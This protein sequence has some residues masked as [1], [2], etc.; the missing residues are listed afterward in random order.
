MATSGSIR[1]LTIEGI[2][3]DVM[4]DANFSEVF[5]QY[6]VEVIATSGKGMKKFTKRV[7]TVEG[8]V[9]GTSGADRERLK[10]W[11]EGLAD[12]KF[13]YTNAAGDTAKA[14]GHFNIESNESEE[15]RT[16]ITLMPT[17]GNWTVF[18]AS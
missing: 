5:S 6:E 15:N 2:P 8:V 9:L 13:S 11:N 17:S 3:F 7:P 14:Q 16:T 10:A 18:L 4:A 12:L 1:K